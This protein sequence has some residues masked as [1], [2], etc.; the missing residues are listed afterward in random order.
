LNTTLK[1][2]SSGC[3]DDQNCPDGQSCIGDHTCKPNGFPVLTRIAVNS[4]SC[5]GCSNSNVEEGLQ[6][7]L[8]GRYGAEC[9]TNSLDNSDQVD[10]T[11]NH[12]AVFNGTILGGSDDHGLGGCNNVNMK[13]IT[14]EKFTLFYLV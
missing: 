5:S 4:K 7:H 10:Y 3:S 13:T 6:L 8:V 1:F 9:S 11:S 2:L 14:T 12:E